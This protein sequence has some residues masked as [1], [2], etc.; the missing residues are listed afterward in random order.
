MAIVIKKKMID[1]VYVVMFLISLVLIYFA[2]KQFSNTKTLLNMGIRTTARVVALIEISG[3][4]T[5]TYKP[6]F[7]FTDNTNTEITFESKISSRPAPYKIDNIVNIIYNKD[8]D[9]R[10]VVS[11]WGLYR[12]SII[13]LSIAMPLL[14][15]GGGYLLY[16]KG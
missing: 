8:T 15:I 4:D 10:R 14:I 1:Y 13:L 6:V 9:E 3:E 7:Q 2:L 5:N 11:F 16:S 12:W